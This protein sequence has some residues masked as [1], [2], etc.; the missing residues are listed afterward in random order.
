MLLVTVVS[1]KQN[2]KQRDIRGF[3]FWDGFCNNES[4]IILDR[5]Y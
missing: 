4:E 2:K 5:L 1:V 3:V